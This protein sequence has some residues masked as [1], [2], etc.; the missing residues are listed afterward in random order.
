MQAQRQKEE[1]LRRQ[2]EELKQAWQWGGC[3]FSSA[4]A[5]NSS[6]LSVLCAHTHAP[7]ST[8]MHGRLNI[9]ENPARRNAFTGATPTAGGAAPTAAEAAEAAGGTEKEA[10]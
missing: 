8:H 2:Q 3:I 7:T 5:A 10:L 4:C 9:L 1:E 6:G